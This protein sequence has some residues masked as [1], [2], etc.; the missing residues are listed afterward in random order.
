MK[1]A[2]IL[3]QKLLSKFWDTRKNVRMRETNKENWYFFPKQEKRV[4]IFKAYMQFSSFYGKPLLLTSDNRHT[5]CT[6]LIFNIQHDISM[7]CIMPFRLHV[8][9]HAL[10]THTH[11]F[12]INTNTAI[13][14]WV[15]F[16]FPLCFLRY[17]IIHQKY[18]H[19]GSLT[20]FT[21][22]S[23]IYW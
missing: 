1:R 22:K 14:I 8:T 20:I 17:N 12:T 18:P 5:H 9:A 11:L 23:Y 10:F 3:C 4:M 6:V 13:L 16:Y 19:E 7:E 21:L 15:F 2:R